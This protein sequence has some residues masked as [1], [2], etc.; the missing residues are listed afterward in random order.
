V[1]RR[2]PV[3][4]AIGAVV[5]A[6]LVTACRP[7]ASGAPPSPPVAR[8]VPEA[9]AS[10]P[11]CPEDRLQTLLDAVNL[12]RTDRGLTP[13]RPEA[14]LTEAARDHAGDLAAHRLRG[15]EGSDGALPPERATTAGYPWILVGENVATGF[16]S[17]S[18]V[19]S[20]WMASPPHRRILLNPDFREAG[21]GWNEGDPAVG[22]V[23]VLV[24][25]RRRAAPEGPSGCVR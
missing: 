3:A 21:I 23:W 11:A 16:T 4:G 20:G 17:P 12:L 22:P 25:G 2:R 19:V 18:T 24:V 9:E 14:R 8:V 10:G 1:V 7:V 5:A 6:T 13:L 15:H